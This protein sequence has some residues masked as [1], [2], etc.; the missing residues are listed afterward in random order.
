MGKVQYQTARKNPPHL[1]CICPSVAAPQTNYE[2]YFTNGCLRTEYLEQLDLLGFGLSKIIM[3]H[4]YHT[5]TWSIAQN[6]NNYPQDIK[7]PCFMI[8]GWYDHNTELMPAFFEALRNASPSNVKNQ[9]RLLLG[10]WAHGGNRASQMGGASQGEL[11]F[12]N[13]EHRNDSMALLFFDYHLRNIANNWNSSPIITYYQIGYN[14]WSNSNEWPLAGATK[15]LSSTKWKIIDRF[16]RH[17]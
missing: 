14:V 2:E 16:T 4:P 13:A 10:P 9:H 6:A 1:V 8:G 3:A 5:A 17:Q 7:V 12:K 11:I 15:L